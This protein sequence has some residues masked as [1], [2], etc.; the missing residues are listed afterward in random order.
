MNGNA[1]MQRKE[2]NMKNQTVKFRYRTFTYVA[3]SL[4]HDVGIDDFA[5]DLSC[6]D[7]LD[8]DIDHDVYRVAAD[9]L[10]GAAQ[11]KLKGETYEE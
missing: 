11:G 6:L 8:H 3:T 9:M 7:D 2:P 5:I 10:I 4:Y 1:I